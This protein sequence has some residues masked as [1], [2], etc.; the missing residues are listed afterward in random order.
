MELTWEH[1]DHCKLMLDTCISQ[2]ETQEIIVPDACPDIRDIVEAGGQLFVTDRSIENGALVVNGRIDG[3][4]LYCPEDAQGP[5]RM[6]IR[7]PFSVKTDAAGCSPEGHSIIRPVLCRVDARTLN[8]RKV[9]VRADLSFGVTLY[10]SQVLTLCSGATCEEPAGIQKLTGNYSA[11]LT[12]QVR[13]KH[14]SV[15][16]EVRLPME[17][18]GETDL[19]CPEARAWCTECRMVGNKLLFKGEAR[20]RLR[21]ISQGQL[22]STTI[23]VGFSQVI[24]MD[25]VGEQADCSVELFVS[26]L[27]CVKAGSDGQ[28]LNVTLELFG[29]AV[30]CQQLSLTLLQDAYSTRSE[31]AVET[32]NCHLNELLDRSVKPRSVREVFETEV[33]AKYVI[34]TAVCVCRTDLVRQ[35]DD[36]LAQTL[37]QIQVMYVDTQEQLRTVSR[38]I[39]VSDRVDEPAPGTCRLLCRCISE[40]FAAIAAGGIEVHFDLEFGC[41]LTRQQSALMIKQARLSECSYGTTQPRPSAVLRMPLPGER[42]WDI[43]KAYSTT[44]DQICQANALEEANLPTGRMLLIP[45]GC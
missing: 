4:V 35:G 24:E 40:P 33:Q 21:C 20:V 6:E 42:L 14:V 27:E 28:M 17:F 23:P 16:E 13:E 9:L 26:S 37:L 45:L 38:S 34:D 10:E 31:L 18:Q 11:Y 8:P 19:V 32:E 29:Q 5:C 7:M 39:T 30:V 2:E 25:G 12:T 22:R 41:V 43:A 3:W 15:Y 1:I 44:I 36:T